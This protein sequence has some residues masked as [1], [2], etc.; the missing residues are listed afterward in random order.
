[1]GAEARYSQIDQGSF[2]ASFDYVQIGFNGEENTSLAFEM[3]DG[4]KKGD[5]YTWS[6]FFQRNLSKNLALN[7]SYNGR[8]SKENPVIHSGGVQVRAFF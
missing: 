7:V 6:L 3:L 4:L 5:N 2:N 1:L 8:K